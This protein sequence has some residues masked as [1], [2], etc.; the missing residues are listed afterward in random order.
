MKYKTEHYYILTNACFSLTVR[1]IYY[2]LKSVGISYYITF[3]F[4]Y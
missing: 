2:E 1:L 3:L 4:H